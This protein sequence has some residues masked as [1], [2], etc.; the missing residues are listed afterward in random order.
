MSGLETDTIG[1]FNSLLEKQKYEP[2]EAI[3][4]TVLFDDQYELLHDGINLNGVAPISSRDYF[5][6]GSTALLDAIGRTI[7]KIKTEHRNSTEEEQAENVMFIITTDG[8]ENASREYRFDKIKSMIEEQ[9][10]KHG[11]NFLFIGANIDAIET[12]GKFGITSDYAMQYCHN[13]RGVEMK[14]EAMDRA[15][16]YVRKSMPI[17]K[18]W[19]EDTGR[20]K[21]SLKT[22]LESI[23]LIIKS[24]TTNKLYN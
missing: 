13:S 18:D 9:K 22:N 2:G 1:G 5:V 8:K 6:R 20:V 16:S 7:D 24:F 4:T 14:Y 10:E 23:I 19:K 3:I 11:W 15:V 12:A 21:P 17:S